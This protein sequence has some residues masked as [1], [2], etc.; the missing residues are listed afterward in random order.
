[1]ETPSHIVKVGSAVQIIEKDLE[2]TIT[3]YLEGCYFA[4]SLDGFIDFWTDNPDFQF[5][6]VATK[7][8]ELI[9]ARGLIYG[10]ADSDKKSAGV[11]ERSSEIQELEKAIAEDRKQLNAI[12]EEYEQVEDQRNKAAADV[13][14]LREAFGE[15]NKVS[16]TYDSDG[17]TKRKRLSAR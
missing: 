8:G 7:N 10:G 2:A 5:T 1:M 4:E 6:L 17:R 12:R 9:D 3:R 14:S 16:A 15:L 13:E 11:L